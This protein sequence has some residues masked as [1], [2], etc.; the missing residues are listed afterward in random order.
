MAIRSEHLGL[1]LTGWL[2]PPAPTTESAPEIQYCYVNG[3]VMRDKLINHAIRQGY[4]EALGLECS[5]SF[6]PLPATGSHQVD[7]NVHPAKY[8]VRFHESRLVHDFIIGVVRDALM[9]G[10]AASSA[11]RLPVAHR[12]AAPVAPARELIWEP[13]GAGYVPAPLR[14]REQHGYQ[15]PGRYTPEPIPA[16]EVAGFQA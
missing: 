4:L 15:A 11:E 13:A 9:Q 12:E 16:Q 2:L 8:E 6:C 5:P 14:S 7:V 3:R 10:V 1:T